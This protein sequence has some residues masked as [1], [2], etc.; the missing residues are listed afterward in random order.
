[1]EVRDTSPKP[2]YEPLKT[3]WFRL[4]HLK[5]ST[6]EESEIHCDPVPYAVDSA[7]PYYSLS[8][9]WG[10]D[11]NLRWIEINGK[12]RPNFWSALNRFRKPQEEICMRVDALCINQDPI[13]ERSCAT[14]R[15]Q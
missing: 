3:G 14:N 9:T 1:M 8:Y 4:L 11:D 2:H 6:E 12:P 5:P 15:L 7:P 10:P 13:P